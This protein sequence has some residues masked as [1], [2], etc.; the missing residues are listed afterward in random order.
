M[1]VQKSGQLKLMFKYALVKELFLS[2]FEIVC[3]VAK[4]NKSRLSGDGH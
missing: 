1:D 2:K 4:S 3:I